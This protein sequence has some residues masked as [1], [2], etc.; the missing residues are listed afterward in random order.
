MINVAGS[1]DGL[2]ASKTGR[3]VPNRV[4]ISPRLSFCCTVYSNGP[5][6][7]G[8]MDGNGV[9]V[10][11]E[12]GVIVGVLVGGKGVAVAVKV[13]VAVMVGV[14]GVL[15]GEL[16]P[17]NQKISAAAPAMS[18]IAAPIMMAIGVLCRIC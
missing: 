16:S 1:M 3:E 18:R 2:R 7:V 11:A 5:A 8:V 13:A 4:A 10:G 12:V 9:S 14:G 17:V 6:G 15:N